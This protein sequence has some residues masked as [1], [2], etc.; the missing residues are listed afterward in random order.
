MLYRFILK[1]KEMLPT[2]TCL[3]ILCCNIFENNVTATKYHR[4]SISLHCDIHSAAILHQQGQMCYI[5]RD[6]LLIPVL[7]SAAGNSP[8]RVY[9]T[10]N[11]HQLLF[12]ASLRLF[13]LSLSSQYAQ[14]ISLV[15]SSIR[16]LQ[17]IKTG[18]LLGP[19][20]CKV[21]KDMCWY[22]ACLLLLL[23]DYGATHYAVS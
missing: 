2:H 13:S 7:H 23:R 8:G 6:K 4:F 18:D 12:C 10:S 20:E 14:L 22:C 9:C 5:R 11:P 16:F 1:C 17:C 21:R 3:H 19:T 15:F